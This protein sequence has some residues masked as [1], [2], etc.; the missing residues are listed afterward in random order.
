MLKGNVGNQMIW[1]FIGFILLCMFMK[2]KTCST[3]LIGSTT[4]NGGSPMDACQSHCNILTQPNESMNATCVN[5]CQDWVR[6][7]N[8]KD[9][10]IVYRFYDRLRKRIVLQPFYNHSL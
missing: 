4:T 5:E 1:I 6:S 10:G 7:Q 3:S 9:A 8:V 2:S